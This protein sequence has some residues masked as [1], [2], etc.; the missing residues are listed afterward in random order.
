MS[1]RHT[2]QLLVGC[3]ACVLTAV[4]MCA[5]EPNLQAERNHNKH[6]DHLP[7]PRVD[8]LVDITAATR[9]PQ[10]LS[11]ASAHIQRASKHG[12]FDS[13]CQ[14]QHGALEQAMED[15][16]K[17]SY[18]TAEQILEAL[19]TRVEG[20]TSSSDAPGKLEHDARA[21]TTKARLLRARALRKLERPE[22]ALAM[23][24]GIQ[25]KTPIDDYKF[26][27]TGKAF[28]DLERFDDALGAWRKVSSFEDSPMS[29]RARVRIGHTLYAS[30]RYNEAARSLES[31]DNLYR[32]YPRRHLVLYQIARSYEELGLMDKAVQAY[33][34]AW[35]AFPYKREGSLARK[36]MQELK[37]RGHHPPKIS[38]E[39]KFT[40]YRRLRIN[41]H[42]NIARTLFL[43][44]LDEATIRDGAH[45]AMV[46]SIWYQ[47]GQNAYIPKNYEEAL[48]YFSKVKSAYETGQRAGI[49]RRSFYTYYARTVGKFGR[50]NEGLQALDKAHSLSSLRTR[51][52]RRAE[53]LKSHA[54]YR[55]AIT[56]YDKILSDAEK[57]S[58]SYTWLLYK[59]GQLDK[60][61]KGFNRLASR[62]GG[63]TEAKYMYWSARSLERKGKTSD[64]RDAFRALAKKHGTTYYGIQA[65]NRLD[66]IRHRK[67]SDTKLLVAT[68]KLVQSTELALLAFDSNTQTHTTPLPTLQIEK[69]T[70]PK[71]D[72]NVIKPTQ[73]SL[74]FYESSFC[75]VDPNSL[76]CHIAKA[77]FP[78][79]PDTNTQ[80][81][82]DLEHI[83]NNQD[84]MGTDLD[85]TNDRTEHAGE[86]KRMLYTSKDNRRKRA[87]YSTP[88]RIFWEGR[89]KSQLAF[90]RYDQG[91]L[92]GPFPKTDNAYL[93][94]SHKGGLNRA[95]AKAK[96]IFPRL[97][98]AR[99]LVDI[100]MN[101]EARWAIRHVAMEFRGLYR[102]AR[103]RGKPKQ[104]PYK[105]MAPLIDNR[106]TKKS[107]W[108]Y[109][110]KDFR[111]PVPTHAAAKN[112][113]LKRQQLIHDT[114]K[115]LLPFVVDAL[116]D[117]G[118][119][120]MVRRYSRDF[121]LG[122]GKMRL[123]QLYPRA[124]PD[125]VLPAAKKYGVNPY[126]IWALMT[127]ESSFN[128]DS[129]S[130]AQALG[131][132]QVIPRTGLKIA[133]LLGDPNHGHYDLLDEDVAIE[134]GVFYIGRVIRKFH[135]QEQLAF[136]GYN[137]GPHR[138]AEWLDQRGD[139]PLDEFIEEIPHNQAREYTKKVTRF[140]GLYMRTY[141][142]IDRVYIGQNLR[143]DYKKMPNF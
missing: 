60:A 114:K 11:L 4:I 130:T 126:A 91:E 76:L 104:L 25:G 27:I 33:Q 40:R 68:D 29:H 63:K 122:S 83:E 121:R 67:H 45:S 26:W 124:F 23:L 21:L 90:A 141:E 2:R 93:S 138:I 85:P 57:Q 110:E 107:T 134:H 103:P 20:D 99:W 17:E 73:P 61:T 119:Y 6:L 56:L 71:A 62:S 125:L 117:V 132:L 72:H 79:I 137:G 129:V 75:K 82:G 95:I 48:H 66:D 55:R 143:R 127:V 30:R 39:D 53:Y 22:D 15:F 133:E 37:A 140:I 46:H 86:L 16:H 14:R 51:Q 9:T 35:F 118:D 32:D 5:H 84:A 36:R 97:V 18:S 94:P 111:F 120:Y 113:L 139:Q 136:A 19:I 105:R 108:G 135:G 89:D 78:K 47:L 7:I 34:V 106:R 101:K 44:L 10:V 38:I 77:Q 50:L 3:F 128:P 12:Y 31:I 74:F 24:H 96:D 98:R 70:Q 65:K 112:Q 80:A 123:R 115:E 81:G 28:E 41:K 1:M 100:A 88:A 58:W 49:N 102:S 43:E 54:R 109:I 52:T 142:H 87:S 69:R 64:A 42:W 13:V 116:K 59:T 8:K 92:I 131:L